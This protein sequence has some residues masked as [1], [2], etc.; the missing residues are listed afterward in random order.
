[1]RFCGWIMEPF[2]YG[3][4]RLCVCSYVNVCVYCREIYNGDHITTVDNVFSAARKCNF[5]VKFFRFREM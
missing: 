2:V 4:V 3:V 5:L 1:M